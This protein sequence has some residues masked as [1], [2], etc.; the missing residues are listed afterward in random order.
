MTVIPPAPAPGPA[1][2]PTPPAPAPAPTPPEPGKTFTQEDITRIA[3]RE[4]AEGRTAATNELLKSL[5][6]ETMEQAQEILKRQRDADEATKTQQQKDAERA[7]KDREEAAKEKTSATHE[8]M[9]AK[10]ERALVRAGVQD[11]TLDD[12]AKL[13]TIDDPSKADDGVIKTAV[14]ALKAR[15]PMLFGP[16][17]PEPG[18][19][20]PKPGDPGPGPR[21]PKPGDIQ[22]QAKAM[23][24]QR[25]G[26]A[27]AKNRK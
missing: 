24:E 19:G 20:P 16:A 7:A 2:A 25:H 21:P 1:P 18:S 6:V 26:A 4:K 10:I 27:L 17:S 23:L 11:G 22:G 8:R 14:E 15:L 3:T 9:M 13:V 5:G 12:V